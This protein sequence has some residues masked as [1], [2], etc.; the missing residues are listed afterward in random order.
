MP[1][2]RALDRP[3]HLGT[4]SLAI[5][6]DLTLTI[7]WTPSGLISITLADPSAPRQRDHPLLPSFVTNTL[8]LLSAYFQG[9]P[10]S[11]SDIPL[12]LTPATP[13]QRAVWTACTTIPWGHTRPYGSIAAQLGN[14]NASRPVGNAL[15]RNPLPIIIPCHR[16]IRADGTLGGYGLGLPLKA[17]LL[18]LEHA[19]VPPVTPP[20]SA[21][22]VQNQP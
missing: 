12:C 21:S 6:P 7:T 16:V 15:A 19:P 18:A 13:F 2:S 1:R 11:F 14:P 20:A 8:R 4:S 3:S 22:T 10:T 17:R 5:S 9:I